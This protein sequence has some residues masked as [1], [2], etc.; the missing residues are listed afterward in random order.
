MENDVPTILLVNPYAFSD[1]LLADHVKHTER[2]N[3][4]DFGSFLFSF[5]LPS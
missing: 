1:M 2:K 4:K 5:V 3:I